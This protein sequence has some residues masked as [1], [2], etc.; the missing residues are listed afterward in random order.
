[1]T[2]AV[3]HFAVSANE[4]LKDAFCQIPSYSLVVIGESI[5]GGEDV[6]TAA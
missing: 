2:I 3:S 6:D 5:P 1:M 4:Q